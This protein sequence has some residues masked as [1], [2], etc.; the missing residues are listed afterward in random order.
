M[1][2]AG[3]SGD[4]THLLTSMQQFAGKLTENL[5]RVEVTGE[6]PIVT[7]F[8][9]M[10]EAECSPEIASFAFELFDLNPAMKLPSGVSWAYPEFDF[11]LMGGGDRCNDW[12]NPQILKGKNLACYDLYLVY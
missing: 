2:L 4:V 10:Q 6:T 8:E 7:L 3:Y 12:P 1:S 5:N 9:Q 11:E